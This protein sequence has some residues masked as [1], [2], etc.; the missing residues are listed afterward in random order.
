M[1]FIIYKYTNFY[2]YHFISFTFLIIYFLNYQMDSKRFIVK[3][4]IFDYT[5]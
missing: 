2:I 4:D 5:S 1:L 3:E